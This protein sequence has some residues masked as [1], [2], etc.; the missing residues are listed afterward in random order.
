MRRDEL[1]IFKPQKLGNSPSAGGQRT[2]QKVVSGKLNDVFDGISAVGY[3]Q[4]AVELAKV[5]PGVASTNT[6]LLKSAHVYFSESPQDPQVSMLIVE[7]DIDDAD[8]LDGMK[9]SLQVGRKVG[10]LVGDLDAAIAGQD[11]IN[12][13]LVVKA[14][15]IVAITIEYSGANDTTF[16]KSTHFAQVTEIISKHSWNGLVQ[17]GFFFTP[18]LPFALPSATLAING[19]KP[20][21]KL[22]RTIYDSSMV[23]YHGTT[24]L[25]AA[26]AS[27]ATTLAVQ[28]TRAA[29]LPALTTSKTYSGLGQDAS[30][31]ELVRKVQVLNAQ[32]SQT[33]LFPDSDI[34]STAQAGIDPTVYIGYVVNGSL[35]VESTT[36]SISANGVSVSLRTRP[37]AGT[38]VL[39]SYLS[40]ARYAVIRAYS[41][42]TTLLVN[43]RVIA[44]TVQGHVVG[45]NSSVTVNDEAGQLMYSKES[46]GLSERVSAGTI[47]YATGHMVL[48][49]PWVSFD[50]TALTGTIAQPTTIQFLLPY[51]DVIPSTLYVS[52]K[53]AANVLLTGSGASNGAITGANVS[54]TI[55][56]GLV[57]LTFNTAVDDSTIRLDFSESTRLLPPAELYGVNP[58]QMPDSG[59]TDI[60]HQWGLVVVSDTQT[61][62][63]LTPTVGQTISARA[64][65]FIAVRGADGT[66]LWSFTDEYYAYNK[67]T[68][69]ITINKVTGV[70]LPLIVTD[71]KSELAMVK[72]VSTNQL[73]LTS[74]LTGSYPIGCVV[75]SVSVLGDLQATV[76]DVRDAT[77]WD[78]DFDLVGTP[79]SA[80]LNTV[81]F[82]IQV[83]NNAAINE[84]WALKFDTSTAFKCYGK[85]VGMIAQGSTLQAF[86]PMNPSTNQPYFTISQQAFGAGW[87]AGEVILF[88]T[89]AAAKPLLLMRCVSPGHS[90]IEQDSMTLMFAGNA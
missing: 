83:T 6:E 18:A 37:D 66:D 28:S 78:G 31:V 51:P 2:S 40:S 63:L 77:A 60:F 62:S 75:S 82:P 42:E 10:D 29:V 23:K 9:A 86:S 65:A 44:G 54:G 47:D 43:K 14:G 68:G 48:T 79:T 73:T 27:G 50:V 71:T 64:N 49:S 81:D 21:A 7:S 84:Q 55:S 52:A 70:S 35:I 30:S 45:P 57:S 59:T 26:A 58:V 33:Y 11:R 13:T 90:A 15:D 38:K 76:S 34:F 67:T 19:Q 4:G 46:N 12:S 1:A 36:Y 88:T 8:L 74:G 72:S 53:T 24:K 80:N 22:R 89:I 61:Q 25:T 32:S 87:S 56:N 85:G 20:C 17:V 69:Q 16:P 41:N 39:L 5:Y 3:G